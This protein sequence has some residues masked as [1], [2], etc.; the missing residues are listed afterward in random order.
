MT[1]IW[2]KKK[3]ERKLGFVAEFCPIC[4]TPRKFEVSRVGI[5][6]HIYFISVGEGNLAGHVGCCQQCGTIIPVDAGK[7]ET[8]KEESNIALE[9][10][11]QNTFPNLYNAYAERLDI[12]ERL[13]K[14]EPVSLP[15]REVWLMEPFEYL[16]PDVEARFTN[17]KLDKESNIG[18]VVTVLLLMFL[19]GGFIVFENS[20]LIRDS[21]IIGMGLVAII[22]LIY[23]I[24]QIM[25]APNRYMERN[26]IPR[27]SQA[28]S[29]LNPGKQEIERC[30]STL[31]IKGFRIGKKIKTEKLLECIRQQELSIER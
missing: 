22:G 7:Y 14:R 12:E 2:G 17:T 3:V 15:N 25:L 28:L 20:A 30:L 1:V 23:T 18:C 13:K 27:L 6:S 8:F 10:L 31:K 21:L 24:V 26:I 5:A 16:I 4:R 11:V 9:A 29:V 19:C